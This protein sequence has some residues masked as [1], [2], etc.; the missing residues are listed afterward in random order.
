MNVLGTKNSRKFVVPILFLRSL[1]TSDVDDVFD[2]PF[3]VDCLLFKDFD[4][5][6]VGHMVGLGLVFS[7]DGPSLFPRPLAVSPMWCSPQLLHV[8]SYTTPVFLSEGKLVFMMFNKE[9][10]VL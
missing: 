5:L 3:N 1:L 9:L 6:S 7:D 2:F 4:L 8:M 10:R